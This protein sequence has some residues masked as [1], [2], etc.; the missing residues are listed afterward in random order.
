M[1]GAVAQLLSP[2]PPR[3]DTNT[4]KPL[5]LQPEPQST[6]PPPPA[7]IP[8]IS[9]GSRLACHM[10]AVMIVSSAYVDDYLRWVRVWFICVDS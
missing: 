2:F 1:V 3:F 6:L 9:L 10:P 8:L 4:N 7:L 5:F